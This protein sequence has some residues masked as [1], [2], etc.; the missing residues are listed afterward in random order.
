MPKASLRW[1]MAGSL[2]LLAGASGCGDDTQGTG[3]D[4]AG[5]GGS[6]GH[7][8]VGGGGAGGGTGGMSGI[9]ASGTGGSGGM[10]G[11]DASGTGGSGGIDAP[12]ID[13]AIDASPPDAA[14]DA[15]PDA[16]VPSCGN[17][18]LDT[19]E[20]CDPGI[21]S[22]TGKCPTSCPASTDPC[23]QNLL[24]GTGCQVHCAAT[25]VT[26]FINGD[27]CCP[28]VANAYYANDTDCPSVCGNGQFEP[29]P[30]V[31]AELCDI[32]ITSGAGACP[33][34][35]TCAN[36]GD[37]CIIG[38]VTG[39]M[40]QTTCSFTTITQIGLADGCCP[41]GGTAA[42]DPDCSPGC[43]NG[44]LDAGELC[45][46][47]IVTDLANCPASCGSNCTV[48][49]TGLCPTSCTPQSVCFD[50]APV[51]FGTCQA[52]CSQTPVAGRSC[53]D[54]NV[55]NGAEVCDGSGVCQPGT[56]LNCSDSNPC[57]TDT[58][59]TV[60][61]C[62][63]AN[64]TGGGIAG[65]DDGNAC[66]GVEQCVIGGGGTSACQAGTALNCNDNNVCT[67]DTCNTS[68][69]C[70]HTP[71]GGRSC[72]DGDPCNG[73]EVCNAA[74]TCVAGT[75]LT[76]NDNNP[77]TNDA[78][79]TGT[80]C[81]FTN[82]SAGTLCSDGNA[83]N[84]VETCDGA[85]VCS[86][87]IAP[88]CNDG[89]SC[90]AD[91]CVNATPLGQ[92]PCQHTNDP[93]GTSCSNDLCHPATCNAS[94][95]CIVGTPTNCDDGNPCTADSCDAVMG[96][97]HSILTGNSCTPP[98]SSCA[99]SGM[100]DATGTC[101]GQ[102][103]IVCTTG[104][105]CTT[106][107]C[108]PA[109][110]TCGTPQN[111]ANG[112]S[113]D[114]GNACNGVSTCQN[115]TCTAGTV[116]NCND[117]NPCTD[118][119]CVQATPIGQNPCRNVNS[120]AGTSCTN[121]TND[122]FCSPLLCDGAGS[123]NVPG[124]PPNCSDGNVCTDDL[125]SNGAC[126]N[127]PKA[128]GT[129]CSD[130]NACN[131]VETC[132]GGGSCVSGSAPN[133]NDGNPCTT[134]SCVA[135]TPAGQDPCQH[136]NL[137]GQQPGC[138][139]NNAC[140]G[141]EL[142]AVGGNGVSTCVAGTPPNCP[143][144]CHPCVSSGPT[145]FNCTT[146]TKDSDGDGF[147]DCNCSNAPTTQISCGS[148]SVRDCDCNDNDPSVFPCAPE[149][150]DGKD[151]NCNGVIDENFLS[152][153][154][155]CSTNSQ[156]C[157]GVCAF[158]A[159]GSKRCDV[160][161]SQCKPADDT[162]SASSQCCSG[163]CAAD[164]AGVSI[165]GPS[166]GCKAVGA[167]CAAAS[168]CCTLSCDATGHCG[169]GTTLCKPQ[170]QTC[171]TNSECCDNNC[172]GTGTK[173]CQSTVSGGC[174]TLGETCSSNGNCC[175]Q[176]CVGGRC[177]FQTNCRADGDLCNVNSD[178]CNSHCDT[179]THRCDV[180]GS[181]VM[182]G[183]SCSFSGSRNCCSD[184]CVYNGLGTGVCLTLNGC[185]PDGEICNGNND[186]CSFLCS[187]PDSLGLRRCQNPPG[188][189]P[190]GEVCGGQG[191][192]NNCCCPA[193]HTCC[194]PTITGVERCFG[195]VEGSCIP[196]TCS[197]ANQCNT[198]FTCTRDSNCP[199]GQTCNTA[200]GKCTYGACLADGKCPCR[201]DDECC[202][203][204]AGRQCLPDPTSP[205]GR[206]CANVCSPSGGSCTADSDCCSGVC[207]NGVCTTP[208]DGGCVPVGGTCTVT[209][210]CCFGSCTSG[211]CQLGGGF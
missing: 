168:D 80:G 94:G 211:T 84:G 164:P 116:P 6:S 105:P 166:N 123:C 163:D 153:R 44:V 139:D 191:A 13:A 162:C 108:N 64:L 119:S 176:D 9:D 21:A 15:S 39:T 81:V 145:T 198:G 93:A 122:T 97:Q 193:G 12:M 207:Q 131:G 63:H 67:D 92:N 130:G 29:S 98:P 59:D 125:C 27:G 154:Q 204:G 31:P 103:S 135:S 199:S 144:P 124:T 206:S 69:G 85:G 40:C 117:N 53:S 111:V 3:F 65:C 41:S 150:C 8:G 90:T 17:G 149:L 205:T 165:C 141:T 209:S 138:T 57:T 5:A 36:T 109:T 195:T 43:G 87:G 167:T 56:S 151:N 160:G 14:I 173:T 115:G 10:A 72:S 2:L 120:A 170:G 68:S 171:T 74:G 187:T 127:P 55:C 181:C 210:Q 174:A 142:C 147:V 197:T 11:I 172:A 24:V 200:I 156:C 32:A 62:Q 35:S 110:G 91:S 188:C 73:L 106:E 78:C 61:G 203:G 45:D 155:P 66:N 25:P 75:P 184:L 190:A 137:T 52:H 136:A 71:V 192:T 96:C 79:V 19:G 20:L 30:A 169:N 70:V 148:F 48:G 182:V 16:Y 100:C 102:G 175:S 196:A 83:C 101:V 179:T 161:A 76:C 4:A 99:P 37:A 201:F 133:C 126:S 7:G 51:S 183:D 113:C 50:T 121:G 158:D 58:C 186:C 54:G 86:P 28:N 128:A 1:L 180:T 118:D 46:I 140:N 157:S 82:S 34:A 177:Y 178:C 185:Q 60:S 89:N 134:D 18:I 107:V 88:N 42:N 132:N 146:T 152:Y 202:A 22:G 33:T 189:Q 47:C 194:R 49:T 26:Q 95:Q 114:D 159:L 112:T 129:S 23:V 143:D 208:V 77:C 38:T 104:N